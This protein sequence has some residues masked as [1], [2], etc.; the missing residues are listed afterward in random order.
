M[1]SDLCTE[2]VVVRITTPQI[3]SVSLI[4]QNNYFSCVYIAFYL[5]RQLFYFYFIIIHRHKLS[6]VHEKM[7]ISLHLTLLHNFKHKRCS[8]IMNKS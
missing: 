4:H 3:I 5:N 6:V 7:K 8:I 2:D 1:T